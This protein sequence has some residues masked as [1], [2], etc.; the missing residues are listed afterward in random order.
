MSA[1]IIHF[2][3]VFNELTAFFPE[4]LSYYQEIELLIFKGDF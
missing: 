4:F 1:I 3:L 2:S